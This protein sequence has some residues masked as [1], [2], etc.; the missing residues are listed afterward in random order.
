MKLFYTLASA[1]I[2]STS[3]FAQVMEQEKESGS[4][5]T[6]ADRDIVVLDAT[7][8]ITKVISVPFI[9]DGTEPLLFNNKNSSCSCIA[10][11]MPKEVKPG[12]KGELKVHFTAPKAGDYKETIYIQTNAKK[13]PQILKFK[14]SVE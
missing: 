12:E 13:I 3:A 4:K 10:T 6:M 2:I 8:N 5:F 14:A 9:N 1:L 11:E 7:P